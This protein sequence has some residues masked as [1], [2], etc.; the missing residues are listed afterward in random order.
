[1][2]IPAHSD[3]SEGYRALA[4]A[5]KAGLPVAELRRVWPILDGETTGPWWELIFIARALPPLSPPSRPR[6]T[7]AAFFFTGG[8]SPVIASKT[9]LAA[10]LGSVGGFFLVM[11]VRSRIWKT[12]HARE[13]RARKL[14]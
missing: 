14:A 5:M 11:P 2:P 9:A 3:Q 6:A 8:A 12:C 10:R 1:M 13:S 7:A 4:V